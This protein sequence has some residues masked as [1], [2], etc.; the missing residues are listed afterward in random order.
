[1]AHTELDLRGRRAIGNL[2]NVKVSVTQIATHFG[3][4][5]SSV[6]REIKINGN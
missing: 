2:L 5:R 6:Y 3:R 4:H 1:M